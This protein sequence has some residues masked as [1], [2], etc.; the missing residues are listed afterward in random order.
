VDRR[1]R[2]YVDRRETSSSGMLVSSVNED[3][4]Q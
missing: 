1:R 3:E 2:A 4:K